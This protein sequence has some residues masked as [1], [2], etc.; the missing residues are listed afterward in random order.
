VQCRC[1]TSEQRRVPR[2]GK[3]RATTRTGL[4]FVQR[5][6]V[7]E[8]RPRS[9]GTSRRR[10]AA[11]NVRIPRRV[12]HRLSAVG[13]R[14]KSPPRYRTS[15]GVSACDR[16]GSSRPLSGPH[17]TLTLHTRS[18]VRETDTNT[19]CTYLYITHCIYCI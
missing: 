11:P 8:R 13:D 2:S 15:S 9:P 12:R 14:G 4:S 17:K 18:R 19:H 10:R 6:A 3:H 5:P 16:P 7:H 1:D